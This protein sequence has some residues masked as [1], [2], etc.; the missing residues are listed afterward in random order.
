MRTLFG[1]DHEAFR[2]SVREFLDR[3]VRPYVGEF[4]ADKALPRTFWTE[5]GKQG[6][7]GLEVPAEYGGG[8]FLDSGDPGLFHYSGMTFRLDW[9]T[10]R[11]D[12]IAVPYRVDAAKLELGFRNKPP[13]FAFYRQGRRYF[14]NCYNNNPT[15]GSSTAY[16]FVERDH[17]AIPVAGMGR[18]KDWELLKKPEF[19]SRWPQGIDPSGD[20]NKN[21]AVFAWSDLN[22]DGLITATELQQ[23]RA[24]GRDLVIIDCS[25]DLTNPAAGREMYQQGHVPG[26]FYLHLDNE[27]SGPKTG[28]N[29]R[30]PL[31]DADLFVAR[32][33]ALGVN[34][35]TM[36][37]SE[38]HTS[39][40]QSH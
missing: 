21:P 28:F 6:L 30:H 33:R 5:A 29:G 27:L 2:D 15:G 4:A 38:E 16:L 11:N 10:G 19:R 7:L 31:P 24:Q 40:L 37:R 13:E 1:P 18:A 17:E 36:L 14:S 34:D 8:G 32:L 39:E 9:A 35:D 20:P 26:A 23:L 3:R 22:G 25:F 12:L